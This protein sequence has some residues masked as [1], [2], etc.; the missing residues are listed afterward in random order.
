[1]IRSVAI[2]LFIASISVGGVFSF[3]QV[4]PKEILGRK[5]FDSFRKNDF[6]AFYMS[7]IFS[8]EEDA[9][10]NF[11]F[12]IKNEG[13]RQELFV[14]YKSP[15]PPQSTPQQMWEIA[16]A[17]TWRDQWRHLAHNSPQ[18][19]MLQSFSPI[20]QDAKE[21]GIQ[22]ESTELLAIEVLLNVK[23]DRGKFEVDRDP[24]PGEN[25]LD[26]QTLYLDRKLTYRLK[27]DQSTHGC[28]FMIGYAPEDSEQ[29]YSKGILGNGSG[30]ADILARFTTQFPDR[31][32][33]FCPDE[34]G[35][36]G[37][38]L[39]RDYDS[40][41]KPNQ[42]SNILLT[43]SYGQPHRA[44]QILVRNVLSTPSGEVFCERPEWLGEVLLP[45]G[46]NFPN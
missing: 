30:Q 43:F 15:F 20:L 11:L 1:M 6:R 14:H 16:F 8:I 35:A 5:V 22:W 13:L 39:I 4:H 18:Q 7:S 37:P 23:W 9:F 34:D 27:L 44:Y 32:Y 19:V 28:A 3:A 2:L 17:H 31:L 24:L 21:N 40:P 41:D 25:L 42:R 10:R 46:L 29:I 36:G 26:S 33:Y 45:R 12:N 38:I